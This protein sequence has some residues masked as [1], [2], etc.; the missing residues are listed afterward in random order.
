MSVIVMWYPGVV[1]VVVFVGSVLLVVRVVVYSFRSGMVM[2]MLVFVQVFV[3]VDMRMLVHMSAN[4]GMLV[5][6]FMFMGV[7]MSV[8]VLMFMISFHNA[9]FLKFHLSRNV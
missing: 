9:S 4:A 1:R 7:L 5:F 3:L 6:V 8:N 2:G